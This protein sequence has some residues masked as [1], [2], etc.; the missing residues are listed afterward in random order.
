MRKIVF[1][2]GIA[3]IV[4]SASAGSYWVGRKHADPVAPMAAV[5]TP[6]QAANRQPSYYRDPM[7]KPDYSPVPKKDSMGMDYIPVYEDE[8]ENGSPQ[9]TATAAKA[10]GKILY[11][12]NPMGLPDTSPVPKKDSMGMEYIPVYD[13]DEPD[14]G[15]IKIS[16]AKVQKLGV[17]SAPAEMR[18]LTRAIRA[19]GT[20]QTDERSL[21]A[22]NTKFEGWIE[23]L[24]VN[25]T[26]AIVH[27]GQPLM[28][29]YAPELVAVQE[30]YLLALRSQQAL[31][32]ASHDAKASAS[33]LAN[34][35]LERL[36]TWGIP[37][38]QIKRLQRTAT[39]SRTLTLR[40]PANGIVMEKMAVEGQRF[41]PGEPLYKIADLSTVWLIA[42]VFE[43]DLA[44]IHEGETATAKVAAYP[45]AEFTGKVAFIYPTVATDT[46]TAKIRIAISN[47]DGR[48]KTDMFANVELAAP[49]TNG[50]VIAV[51]DSALLDSGTRQAVLVDRGEGRFEPREV[52]VGAKADGFYEIMH[53][54]ATGENVVVGANFLIDAES[55]IK[56]ALKAFTSS[57]EPEKA[58]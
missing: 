27:R 51:P 14:D 48:L 2:I 54:L 5:V 31:A 9:S 7:G 1:G 38:D 50:P 20:I 40:A 3:A 33:E 42:D 56:T 17:R 22:V 45:G 34:A 25:T 32:N 18:E 6:A 46:R 28:E 15:S 29:V 16:V 55:N 10:P 21:Y 43:Q 24:H 57:Q 41:M 49:L 30:E 35:A 13:G 58:Q 36:R 12:R 52:K 23:K 11:Y 44:A 37:D 47:P 53:G 26:G 4:G 19:V 39:A 8:A